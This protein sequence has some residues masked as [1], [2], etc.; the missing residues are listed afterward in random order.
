MEIILYYPGGPKF[1]TSSYQKDATGVG[2]EESRVR[3]EASRATVIG[4][5]PGARNEDSL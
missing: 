3:R 1:I 2:S 5:G 4:C